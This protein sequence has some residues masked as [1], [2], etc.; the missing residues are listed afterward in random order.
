V[1]QVLAGARERIR[2]AEPFER[3]TVGCG[4]FPLRSYAYQAPEVRALAAD[5]AAA[6]LKA[7]TW[8][9]MVFAIGCTGAQLLL[10]CSR[11]DLLVS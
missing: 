11:E 9:A 6:A 2:I 5:P 7:A 3:W 8:P 1:L 4:L 10:G